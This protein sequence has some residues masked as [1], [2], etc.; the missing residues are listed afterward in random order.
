MKTNNEIDPVLALL[1][2]QGYTDGDAGKKRPFPPA[3]KA[4]Q[5]IL[6]LKDKWERET[7]EA[8]NEKIVPLDQ[9]EVETV[10]R[11]TKMIDEL[12]QESK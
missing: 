7:L 8:L 4:R 6:K 2:E 10:Q 5:K 12:T 1:Y 3:E 9:S 11:I